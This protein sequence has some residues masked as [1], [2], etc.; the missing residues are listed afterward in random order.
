MLEP[1][2][3]FQL[4]DVPPGDY[5]LAV[6]DTSKYLAIAKSGGTVG[7]PFTGEL[8]DVAIRVPSDDLEGLAIVTRPGFDLSGTVTRDGRPTSNLGRAGVG[9]LPAGDLV[10]SA[11]AGGSTLVAPDGTFVL[12]NLIGPQ[13]IVVS[14]PP[15]AMVQRILAGGVDVTDDGVEMSGPVSIEVVLGTLSSLTGRVATRQGM[16]VPGMSVVA[17]AEDPRLWTLRDT[18]HV[19]VAAAD[20]DGTFRIDGLP[21]GRYYVAAVPSTNEGQPEAPTDLDALDPLIPRASR[22]ETGDGDRRSVVVTID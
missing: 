5:V 3:R 22:V 10:A 18:R 19:R 7:E 6:R 12:R 17:F 9:V 20:L 8:A 14:P 13:R 11:I 16:G 1:D 4:T 21:A 15:G 2:G